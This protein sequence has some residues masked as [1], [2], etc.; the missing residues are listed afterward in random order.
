MPS[1]S[2]GFRVALGSER[3]VGGA[4]TRGVGIRGVIRGKL[5]VDV[6]LPLPLVLIV[7]PGKDC[8]CSH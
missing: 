1:F 8:H 4:V 6:D 5:V 2:D 7:N 3:G